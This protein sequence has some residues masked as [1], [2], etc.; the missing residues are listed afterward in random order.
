MGNELLGELLTYI[1][2]DPS[3][4]TFLISLKEAINSIPAEH[5]T[6][7][8]ELLD[9]MLDVLLANK[10]EEKKQVFQIYLGMGFKDELKS[11]VSVIENGRVNKAYKKELIERINS[12][13]IANIL[14]PIVEDLQDNLLS[15]EGGNPGKSRRQY[16]DSIMEHILDLQNRSYLLVVDRANNQ[17][18]IIDLETQEK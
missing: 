17:A 8:E 3:D 18:M 14:N 1:L 4:R 5:T 7:E 12:I 13:N 15:L 11:Y 16:L 2:S 6:Q 9:R 10:I